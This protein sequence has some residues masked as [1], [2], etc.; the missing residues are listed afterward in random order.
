MPKHKNNHSI[1]QERFIDD[2]VNKFLF[3]DTEIW[4]FPV[5]LFS[6]QGFGYW[7]GSVKPTTFL[8]IHGNRTQ[9]Q[10]LQQDDINRYHNSGYLVDVVVNS[11][12]NFLRGGSGIAKLLKDVLGADYLH[13]NQQLLNEHGGELKRGNAYFINF[14]SPAYRTLKGIIHAISIEYNKTNGRKFQ[15]DL[16]SGTHISTCVYN[17]LTTCHDHHF[18]DIAIPQMASRVGYSIYPKNI[19]PVVMLQATLNAIFTF[20]SK[21]R[22]TSIKRICL[23][24]SN[25]Q[26]EMAMIHALTTASQ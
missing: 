4:V 15:I 7:V 24:P 9:Y 12:N 5:S 14:S 2:S 16:S 25:Q 22:S 26:S 20:L 10:A 13:Q 6:E 8:D 17:S 19:A 1:S 3:F 21:N 11:A 23:H 18:Q